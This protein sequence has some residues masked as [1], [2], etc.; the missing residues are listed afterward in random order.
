MYE[1]N[2]R[3]WSSNG[4]VRHPMWRDHNC[5]WRKER[6]AR[7]PANGIDYESCWG[8]QSRRRR[9]S[10]NFSGWIVNG[11]IIPLVQKGRFYVVQRVVWTLFL[12]H[13]MEKFSNGLHPECIVKHQAKKTKWFVIN[14]KA[15]IWQRLHFFHLKGHTT[16]SVNRTVIVWIDLMRIEGRYYINGYLAKGSNNRRKRRKMWYRTNL[17]KARISC[18]SL[19]DVT[20]TESRRDCQ[21]AVLSRTWR[22]KNE[23]IA[24]LRSLKDRYSMESK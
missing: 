19:E 3:N 16:G 24:G 12:V 20:W 13:E 18:W 1:I 6:R 11:P 21:E 22:S 15:I 10:I 2:W 14:E 17:V 23:D 8:H 5:S 7:C 4:A 9:S